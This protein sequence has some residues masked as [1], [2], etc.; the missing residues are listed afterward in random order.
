MSLENLYQFYV[1]QNQNV[2]FNSKTDNTSI[3]VQLDGAMKFEK[4]DDYDATKGL[5]P[6]TLSSC[7]IGTNLNGSTISKESMDQALESFKNR[8]ILGFIHKVNDEWQFAGHEV[9]EDEN[10]DQVYDEYPVGTV[11]ESC[12]AHYEHNDENDKDYVTANGYI[13]EEYSKAAEILQRESEK[14]NICPLSIEIDIE[15]LS[16]NAK[17]K[18]LNINKFT[19]NGVTILG[20]DEDG[21]PIHPG[22]QGAN[23]SISSFSKQNNSF[24]NDNE[25]LSAIKEL[26]SNIKNFS[27]DSVEGGKNT[28]GKFE[29]LLKKYNK[30]AEDITFEYQNMTDEELTAKFEELFGKK[31]NTPT[32]PTPEIKPN[33]FSIVK[34]NGDMAKFS[35]SLSD[36]QYALYCLVNNTYAEADNAWY[37]ANVYVDDNYVVMEDYFSNNAYRQSYERNDNDFA[38]TGD[39]V[40]VHA[41]Q[42]TDEEEANMK[43]KYENL[44][45]ELA[46]YKKT[47]SDNK[48]KALIESKD[49]SAIRETD[50][51]KAIVSEDNKAE[52]EKLSADELE[53]K[54]DKII[55]QY[56]KAGKLNFAKNDSNSKKTFVTLPFSLDDEKPSR[57]GDIFDK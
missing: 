30:T 36:I 51:F 47:E 40:A 14:G 46:T 8:P 53:G 38:L 29:E 11:P 44:E 13:Y 56:A 28:L 43:S 25:L 52:F 15:E 10:G 2:N 24:F 48:K 41:V 34:P 3:I 1:E 45:K 16:F 39:R 37:K 12:N 32:E 9:H 21:N 4:N 5:L 7:H 42:A 20:Y 50:E 33:E 17:E 57:Y 49:Y 23:I 35:L 18:S 6:V 31:D 26:N 27:K 22:M 19:F 55:T 54:L